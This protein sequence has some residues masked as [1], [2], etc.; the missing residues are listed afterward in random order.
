M[1]GIA[2]DSQVGAAGNAGTVTVYAGSITIDATGQISSNTFG[3]G[4]GGDVIVNAEGHLRSRAI[5][6]CSSS[7]AFPQVPSSMAMRAR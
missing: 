3:S 4:K 2:A 5:R 6:S 1:T 7:P